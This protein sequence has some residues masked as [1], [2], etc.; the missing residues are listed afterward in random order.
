MSMSRR[1]F[2]KIGGIGLAGMAIGGLNAPLFTPRS[3]FASGNAWRFGVMA[4]TQWRTGFNAGGEPAS[5]AVSI[6]NA[7]NQQFIQHDVRFVIQVGDL[8]DKETAD[9]TSAG[10]RSLPTRASAA[11]ALYDAGIGFF[12][13]RGNHEGSKTAAA[14]IP[15]LFPQTLGLGSYVFG[16]QNFQ[17]PVMPSTATD[18][19]GERLRGLTYSFDYENVRCVLIDQFTRADGTS[20]N[21]ST[22]NNA[23]DQVDWVDAMLRSKPSDSHAFVFSHKNLIGQNHKDVLFG[24]SLTSNAAARDQFIKS[25]CDSGVRLHMSGHDHMHHRSIVR[26]SD[27]LSSVGQLICS[28]NSYKF[29]IPRP[30]DDGRETP[31]QQELFTIG[32][33]IVTVDGPRVYVDFYSS[34]HGSNY[35]D[36]DLITP[37]GTFP[38]HLRETFGYSL[39]GRQ[40]E[41]AQGAPYTIVEDRFEGTTAKILDGVNGNSETDYL[42][43]LLTKT[44]NT[45]WTVR[46]AQD[47]IASN[48]LSLWGMADNLSL[49]DDPNRGLD[50]VG[51]MPDAAE[52]KESDVYTLAMTY[53][54]ERRNG[55]HLGNGGFRLAAKNADG[56]WVRAVDMNFGY[57]RKRFAK[58]PW[59]P[60]YELG[61]YGVDTSTKTVWAVI[62]FDGEFAAVRDLE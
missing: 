27:G 46:P 62:N 18:P 19:L 4:D 52:S 47:N 49:W 2:L 20:F 23:V 57:F 43:R 14:E 30:G 48:V 32:Y 33:Y 51:L 37:P 41:V 16:A 12:P 36:I 9:G 10:P 34:S 26:T 15:F 54:D 44:V 28:S 21:N 35:G 55:L 50:L 29:Y 17:S 45:G 24:S 13:V 58:G 38:F 56:A 3:A 31:L 61:T 7:L 53:E 40:F 6:I 42:S 39:N 5:C 8:V 11:Q 59:R 60:G 22:N 1:D 25:L